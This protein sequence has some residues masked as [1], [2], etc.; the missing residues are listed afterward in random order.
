VALLAQARLAARN[1][2]GLE[3]VLRRY[4]AGHSLLADMLLDEAAA[5]GIGAAELKGALRALA[6]RYDHIVAAVSEEYEREAAALS[7]GSERPGFAIIR[8]LLA[9]EPLDA[10][11]LDYELDA[12]HLAVVA[13]GPGASQ[14]LGSLVRRL[15]RRLL[16]VEPHEQS[17]WAWLGGRRRFASEELDFIASY[18]W[19][20]GAALAC[21]EPAAG[22]SGWCLSH[23]QAATALLV[24]KRSPETVVHYADVALLAATL[25]DELLARSPRRAYLAPLE[26]DRDQGAAARA[27]LR[28]YFGAARN[29]SSSSSLSTRSQPSSRSP[30]DSLSW[31]N[32]RTA[33]PPERLPDDLEVLPF[34]STVPCWI[35]HK[36]SKLPIDSARARRGWVAFVRAAAERYGPGGQFWAEHAP[37]V[38]KDGIVIPRPKPIHVWQVC[39]EANFFYFAYPV[40]PTRYARLLKLTSRAI[41]AADPRAD[42]LLSGLFGEPDEGGK[43]GMPAASTSPRWAGAPKTTPTS[44]PSSR[45]SAARCANCAPPTATCWATATGST[46]RRRTGSPG[47]TRA[48]SA[49]SATRSASSATAG[50]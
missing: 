47:K 13:S 30:S 35:S 26:T 10:T 33:T 25:Q 23:R 22:R 11:E 41:K 32:S 50:G 29:S 6:A 44:S 5:A 34:L 37:G 12:N 3:A 17:T 14:A 1:D 49:T 24:A 8:R 21:G 16:L 9:G 19:P 40:S 4:A 36:P 46:S 28:A 43:R 45:A 18:P 42:V 31:R 48:A 15:D 39:N 38:A 7:K 20:E 2:I 27:T